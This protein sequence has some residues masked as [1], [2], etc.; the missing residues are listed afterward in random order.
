MLTRTVENPLAVSFVLSRSDNI[1]GTVVRKV[2]GGPPLGIISGVA[3]AATKAVDNTVLSVKKGIEK[4]VRRLVKPL[5]TGVT[6]PLPLSPMAYSLPIFPTG[7]RCGELPKLCPQEYSDRR[8]Q[9]GMPPNCGYLW[10]IKTM[11]D[12]YYRLMSL[13]WVDES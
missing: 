6:H 12:L 1:V 4:K 7:E 11:H 8:Q 5:K 13:W 3:S 10:V 9:E 2:L